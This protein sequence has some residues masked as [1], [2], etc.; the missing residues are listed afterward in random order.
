MKII[1]F[2]MTKFF[3]LKSFFDGGD[4]QIRNRLTDELNGFGRKDEYLE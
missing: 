2:D 1:Y 4:Y 3:V